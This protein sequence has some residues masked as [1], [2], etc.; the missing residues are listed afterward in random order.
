MEDVFLEKAEAFRRC[1]MEQ[2]DKKMGAQDP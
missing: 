2:I 1:D